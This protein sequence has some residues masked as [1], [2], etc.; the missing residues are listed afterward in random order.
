MIEAYD[1]ASRDFGSESDPYFTVKCGTFTYSNRDRYKIDCSCPKFGEHV[2][3]PATFP[4]V[5][6]VVIECHDYDDLFGDDLIG[7][8]I[9]DLDDRYFT[10][11]WQ[12]LEE[13]PLE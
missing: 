3:F 10:Q 13:K 2:T 9:I 6:P 5:K 12:A 1:L 11:T 8:T 4:G 7:T